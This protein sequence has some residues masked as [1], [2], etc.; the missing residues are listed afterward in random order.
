MPL[1]GRRRARLPGREYPEGL[2]T[3]SADRDGC[4][5]GHHLESGIGLDGVAQRGVQIIRQR[6]P[7]YVAHRQSEPGRVVD[8]QRVARLETYLDQPTVGGKVAH[9][10]EIIGQPMQSFIGEDETIDVHDQPVGGCGIIRAGY[11]DH[12]IDAI[13]PAGRGGVD[14]EGGDATVRRTFGVLDRTA[15]PHPRGQ[16]FERGGERRCPTVYNQFDVVGRV[17]GQGQQAQLFAEGGGR[18][19]RSQGGKPAVEQQAVLSG[20]QQLDVPGAA[21]NHF[22]PTLRQ[23]GEIGLERV[24][25]LFEI[26]AGRRVGGAVQEQHAIGLGAVVGG[27]RPREREPEQRAD[28]QHQQVGQGMAEATREDANRC[29]PGRRPPEQGGGDGHFDVAYPQ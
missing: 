1:P 29:L 16:A 25:G 2:V 12:D 14:T 9:G 17:T 21:P 6:H 3:V 5:F 20:L 23:A 19:L 15:D 10:D 22:P 26:V 4:A 8:R 27:Q 18:C 28:E 13:P 7:D 11:P 24:H